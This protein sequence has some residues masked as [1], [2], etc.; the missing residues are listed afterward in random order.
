MIRVMRTLVLALVIA[1]L[2]AFCSLAE[3][4]PVVTD[5]PLTAEEAAEAEKERMRRAQQMLIDLNLLE[6][7]ADGE[8]GPRTA[9]AIRLFQSRNGLIENGELNDATYEALSRKAEK[10]GAAREVQQRLIDLGYLRGTADGIFGERSASALKLFQAMA[11]LP[12]TG[13]IDDATREAL[14]AEDARAVPSRLSFGDKGDAVVALQEKLK[15]YGFL[16]GKADGSS[17]RT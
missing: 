1:L 7:V 12:A 11:G 14:F 15:Q 2:G 5:E 4:M 16:T 10:A 13:E 3:E 17:P 6:G 8:Y 9:Q